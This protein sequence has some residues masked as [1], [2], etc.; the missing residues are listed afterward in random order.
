MKSLSSIMYSVPTD[1]EDLAFSIND[2]L[3]WEI[4]KMI[5]RGKTIAFAS[6][7]KRQR[8]KRVKEL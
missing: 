1:D 6:H 4:I 3:Q 7:K 2:Q 5:I 8:E